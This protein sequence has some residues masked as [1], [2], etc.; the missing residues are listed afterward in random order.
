MAWK[1]HE[2]AVAAAASCWLWVPKPI[3]QR[4]ACD[5]RGTPQAYRRSKLVPSC[6][7]LRTTLTAGIGRH[8]SAVGPAERRDQ[9]VLVGSQAVTRFSSRASNVSISVSDYHALLSVIIAAS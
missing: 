7:G 9:G 4:W 2:V 3:S 8:H 6:S 1:G 5:V